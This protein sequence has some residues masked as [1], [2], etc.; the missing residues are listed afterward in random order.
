M[1]QF[2][3]LDPYRA[4][5]SIVSPIILL[6]FLVILVSIFIIVLISVVLIPICL[7]LQLFILKLLPRLL[8][9]LQ[10]LLFELIEL[11]LKLGLLFIP[12]KFLKHNFLLREI[13]LG[14]LVVILPGLAGVDGDEFTQF[15]LPAD[16]VKHVGDGLQIARFRFPI[17]VVSDADDYLHVR[18]SLLNF[19]EPNIDSALL[20]FKI[21]GNTLLQGVV[22]KEGF[23]LV[24]LVTHDV[25]QSKLRFPDQDVT[26]EVNSISIIAAQLQ[27]LLLSSDVEDRY[28]YEQSLEVDCLEHEGLQEDWLVLTDDNLA[29]RFLLPN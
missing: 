20:E 1:L 5:L 14:L 12:A 9:R 26:S 7:L 19:I 25:I 2:S 10:K 23:C 21:L 4:L 28:F 18:C 22:I 17:V 15:T 16:D 13:Q 8:S 27:L 11:E 6:L 3:L 29:S 24:S